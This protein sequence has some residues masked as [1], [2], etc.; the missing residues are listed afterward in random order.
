MRKGQ[1]ENPVNW[2]GMCAGLR[3]LRMNLIIFKGIRETA[4]S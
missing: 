4:C 1:A 2:G 3:V